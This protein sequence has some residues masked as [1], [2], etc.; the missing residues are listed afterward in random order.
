M[1]IPR[2]LGLCGNYLKSAL[3][4]FAFQAD[5]RKAAKIIRMRRARLIESLESR[6]LLAG[7]IMHSVTANGATQLTLNYTV[8]EPTTSVDFGFFRSADAVFGGDVA[9]RTITVNK[10]SDLTVGP[11]VKTLTIGSGVGQVPLP[12]AGATEVAEDYYILAVADPVAPESDGVAV[13]SGVYHPAAGGVYVHGRDVVD[14]ISIDSSYRVTL[15][16]VMKQYTASDVNGFR[17]RAHDGND[18]VTATTA[19]K[20]VWA[21]GG[22]GNDIMIGGNVADTLLGDAGSDSLTGGNGNDALNGG[23]DS[24]TYTISGTSAGTDAIRDSG[25]IG[26]D[27]LI[28]GAVNTSIILGTSFTKA[29]SGLEE[30]SA[31]GFAGVNLIGTSAADSHNFTGVTLT[32][33]SMLDGLAGIDT[34]VGSSGIDSFR[35]SA[36]ND[37]IDGALGNDIANFAGLASSYSITPVGAAIQVKDL[38]PTVNGDDGTDTL[39]NIEFLKFLDQTIPVAAVSNRAPTA[40]PDTLTVVEDAGAVVASVLNN[41]TDPDVGDTKR[42]VSVSSPGVR[43][44]VQVA[45]GGGGVLFYPNRAYENLKAG[46]SI[47]ETITYTMAD[48]V[49]AQSTSILVVTVVGANDAPIAFADVST[50]T[51]NDGPQTISVLANDTDI[52]IGDT[53]TVMSVDGSGVPD[54]WELVIIYGV[55]APRLVPGVPAIQGTVSVAPDGQ[56]VIYS[57]GN[58]FQNL[59]SGQTATER[60]HYTMSDAAGALATNWVTLTVQGVNDAPVAVN[61]TLLVSKNAAPVAINVLA[62]DTDVDTGDAK[63]ITSIDTTGLLGSAT[64]LPNGTIEYTVGSAFESL[65][66]TDRATEAFR[67]T[68]VDSAGAQSTAT[69]TLTISGENQVP[70]A[71]DDTASVTENGAPITINVLANDTDPD[72]VDTKTVVAVHGQGLQGTVAIVAGGTS[73]TYTIGNAFQSLAVGATATDVFTYVMRDTG[74]AQ[75]T[76]TVT[77][78]V[79]GANDAP[80]AVANSATTSEDAAPLVVNVLANDSDVDVGD[81]RTVVSVNA[82]NLQGSVAVAP[83]GTGVVYSVGS[84]FQQ[85][86]AGAI[87]TET[88]SYAIADDSGVQSTAN[89][90]MTITGVNDSPVATDNT[91]TVNEDAL[92]STIAVLSNDTD[93]DVGD[94]K[95]VLSVNTAGILGSVS[96][97]ANGASLSYSPGSAFQHLLTGQTATEVFAYTMVDGA[98]AQSTA[99]VTVLVTGLTD[100]PKAVNDTVSTAED[101]GPIVIDV[102]ANDFSDLEARENLTIAGID[103]A[104]QF[105]SMELIL[106]YG[107]GVGTFH[108]GFPRLLGN[109]STDANGRSVL[110]TPLQSL[111]AGEV[112]TDLFKYTVTGSTGGQSFGTVTVSVTGANDAP[113]AVPD[114]AAVGSAS[115]SV[116]IPVLAND[117]DPDTRIDPVLPTPGEFGPWDAT[118]ADVPDTKSI[119]SV[120][121]TG[122]QGS[123][124][125]NGSNLVYTVGGTLLNLGYGATAQETFT[126]TMQDGAGAQ[127]TT[128]VTV[129]VTG[130]NHRPVASGDTAAATEDGSAVQINVLANDTDVDTPFGDSL[131][132]TSTQTAGIQGTVSIASDGQSL[133]YAVGNAYQHLKA[134]ETAIETFGYTVVDNQGASVTAVVSVTITGQNDT[135]VAVANSLSLSEDAAPTTIAVLANDSDVDLNDSKTI[136]SVNSSSLQGTVTIGGGGSHVVYTVGQAFQALNN[137]QSAVE[138]FSYTMVDSAGAQSTASV[139]ITIIGANEPVIIVNPPPPPAGAIVG[140]TGDDI[141]ITAEL[142]DIIYGEAGDDE[143]TSGGGADTVFGGLGRDTIDGGTGNDIISGGADRDDLTGGAG[144]DIFRYYLATESSVATFDRIRDFNA[145]EGDR[146]DLSL[147]DASTLVGENNAFVFATSF[148]G[149]A[150]QLVIVSMGSDLY[151]V[152]GDT[153]GDGVAD[154][155]IEVKAK[156]ALLAS[157]LIL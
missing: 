74:G 60:F 45:S 67:Y 12:G 14:T 58:A 42:V 108:P 130:E 64:I 123:V 100:G 63:T 27:R 65:Q 134:G 36:G 147:I 155:Q 92:A 83:G 111:N 25:T 124:V 37:S 11:H 143:I 1:M 112:G 88:F 53:K 86:R 33:L 136:V 119:V 150:G 103:G 31:N 118:P 101:A 44:I 106:I 20:T 105:A 46:T 116:T 133:Q 79:T 50:S 38:A 84:A 138:T 32:G 80:V 140:T 4:S 129:T 55:G 132:I 7:V 152:R 125:L 131:T 137:G 71:V 21:N 107:V 81:T 135:P 47:V 2:K 18:S 141:L 114:S 110:Y 69:V 102:L 95:R 146:I 91:F 121:S 87:A 66:G 5:K 128:T 126:Y 142:A 19:A 127:S 24:D 68:I 16:G 3:K 9:L 144:A 15:N 104:G 94:T 54:T 26:V 52:D 98:G 28:A 77:I 41:D 57:V 70:T 72:V 56:G 153:N 59:R 43:G 96:I 22:A 109:A 99:T 149:I 97:P 139:T 49:G 73:V 76:A 34:M 17:I 30:I 8:E 39:M 10:A 35:G 13:F 61:D 113:T 75:S 151:H 23:N 82:T 148:T 51:E 120:N 122:L 78:T 40:F 62:N 29:I 6:E 48:A 89:V 157:H 145:S 154:L 156:S 85:L 117:T 90:T 115:T 93:P